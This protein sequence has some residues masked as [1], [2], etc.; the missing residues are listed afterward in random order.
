MRRALTGSIT[1]LSP[2]TA[3]ALS[4]AKVLSAAGAVLLDRVRYRLA[5]VA[6]RHQL[7]EQASMLLKLRGQGRSDDEALRELVLLCQGSEPQLLDQLYEDQGRLGTTGLKLFI[8]PERGPST[9]VV[10]SEWLAQAHLD[11]S[12]Q[13]GWLVVDT[14]RW[15]AS[16]SW[17]GAA[18]C[19]VQTVV[20]RCS[21]VLRRSSDEPPRQ[22]ALGTRPESG[23][24]SGSISEPGRW[25]SG[26]FRKA[27]KVEGRHQR[28]P[29]SASR[30]EGVSQGG[31]GEHLAVAASLRGGV[32][33]FDNRG[34]PGSR[35]IPVIKAGKDVALVGRFG[36]QA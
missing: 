9:T 20:P 8:R 29:G 4:D 21:W 22:Q 18:N 2:L 35:Q 33:G 23:S 10:M 34:A 16:A 1:V 28:G 13:E 36:L 14:T 27:G 11:E 3:L 31:P 19:A 30:Q 24:G 15:R 32:E 12:E 17:A 6:M 7:W 26:R 5:H 25:A